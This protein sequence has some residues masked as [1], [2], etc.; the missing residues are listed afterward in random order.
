LESGQST[1]HNDPWSQTSPETF[2]A[3]V[4]DNLTGGEFWRFVQNGDN[5]IGWVGNDG[6]EYTGNVTGHE[7]DDELF[8]FG[9][10]GSWFWD[11]VGV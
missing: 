11:D 8:T 6:A 4:V 5:A 10:F 1:Y 7:G 3:Q 9:A 2:H